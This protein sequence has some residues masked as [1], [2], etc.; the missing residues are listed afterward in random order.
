MIFVMLNKE[1]FFKW[2]YCHH[3]I[4][5]KFRWWMAINYSRKGQCGCFSTFPDGP[6]QL[7]FLTNNYDGDDDDDDDD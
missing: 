4:L 5:G 7:P 6:V 2:H 3:D 1:Q